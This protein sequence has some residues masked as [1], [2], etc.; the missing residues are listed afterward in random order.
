MITGKD[1]RKALHDISLEPGRSAEEKHTLGQFTYYLRDSTADIIATLLNNLEPPPPRVDYVIWS[2]EHQAWWGPGKHGYT[3]YLT[4]AGHYSRA[5]AQLIAA[6]A[7]GGW[8][9]GKPPPEIA[10]PLRDALE[11]EQTTASRRAGT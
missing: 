9:P 3:R 10:L 2:N 4:Q 7:R 8:D 5:E 6:D 11:A 1:V